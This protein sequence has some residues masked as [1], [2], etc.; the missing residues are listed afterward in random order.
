M[1]QQCAL[2][3]WHVVQPPSRRRTHQLILQPC[4]RMHRSEHVRPGATHAVPYFYSRRRGG[5]HCILRLEVA[6]AA[7][8]IRTCVESGSAMAASDAESISVGA[9]CAEEAPSA[10]A[11]GNPP[12]A[13]TA[14]QAKGK[15]R[16][17]P[18]RPRIDLDEQIAQANK[19]AEVSKKML[20]AAKTAQ[21]NQRKQ[22]QRLIRKAG[23]LSAEDLERIAVLKRCG[24]YADADSVPEEPLVGKSASASSH[25]APVSGPADKKKKL[26]DVVQKIPGAEIVLDALGRGSGGSGSASS[27]ASGHTGA[28]AAASDGHPDGRP[29]GSRLLVRALSGASSRRSEDGAEQAADA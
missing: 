1:A 23:K 19:L 25:E 27:M 7:S 29:R 6:H 4:V 17:R 13:E 2:Y 22:K 28:S 24:L 9:H 16:S 11:R 20:S 8:T 3:A 5:V 12:V 10:A 26:S 21:K 15:A 14:A 18:V